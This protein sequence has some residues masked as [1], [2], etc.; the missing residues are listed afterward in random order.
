[1]L[2]Y[3]K[4]KISSLLIH[5]DNFHQILKKGVIKMARIYKDNSF[6]IGNT[7]L[8]KLNKI[9]PDKKKI[10]L[11]AKIEGRNPGYSVK[12]RIGSSM[13]WDAEEK[14]FL[15]PGM[16]IVEPTS[17]NTGIA[18]AFVSA[19]RG[20]KLT[21]TMPETMSIERRQVL[22]SRHPAPA[23][24]DGEIA[25]HKQHALHGGVSGQAEVPDAAPDPRG[26]GIAAQGPGGD[27]RARIVIRRSDVSGCYRGPGQRSE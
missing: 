14:G 26:A 7:P 8:V 20:Y 18:L 23:A 17:G 6:S 22:R 15:K 12:C 21:L 1:M 5:K 2:V 11:L 24:G 10:T 3:I 25:R 4:H 27:V 19:A 16:N 9:I 13:I